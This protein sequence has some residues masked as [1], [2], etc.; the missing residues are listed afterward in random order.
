M[1]LCQPNTKQVY[2]GEFRTL[3]RWD[4]LVMV[5][6]NTLVMS[7]PVL[8]EDTTDDSVSPSMSIPSHSFDTARPVVGRS[9]ALRTWIPI[10]E[11]R[12]FTL[13]SPVR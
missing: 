1:D 11:G 10:N 3:L 4:H 7:L 13:T 9:C 2:K 5:V 12:R 6:M 8:T